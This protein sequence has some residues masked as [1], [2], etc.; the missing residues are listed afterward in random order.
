LSVEIPFDAAGCPGVPSTAGCPAGLDRAG[1]TCTHAGDIDIV[2]Q[3][4]ATA[5]PNKDFGIEFDEKINKKSSVCRTSSDHPKKCKVKSSYQFG[6]A[7]A[8]VFKYNI[9][10]DRTCTIVDPYIILMK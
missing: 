10:G 8:L 1:F 6:N 5:P 4:S 3:K 9:V 2:W 7:Y